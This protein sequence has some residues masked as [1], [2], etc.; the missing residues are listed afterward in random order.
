MPYLE[1]EELD[2]GG[3]EAAEALERLVEGTGP[4]AE[5][6]GWIRYA[7]SLSDAEIH[8]IETLA[9]EVRTEADAFVVIGIGGSYLGARAVIESLG[10]SHP[11]LSPPDERG[12]PLIFYAGNH[13]SGEALEALLEVLADRSVYLNVISKSGT[14][15]EPGL[16]FRALRNH[17]LQ[18]YG[19]E[20]TA[21]RI[22]TTTDATRGVLR[23]VTEEEGYRS[24]TIPGDVGGRYSVLTPVG[25]FPI[26]V[27]GI[28][29]DALLEGAASMSGPCEARDP[30][31][32]PALVYAAARN[33][34]WRKGFRQEMLVAYDPKFQY[35][36]EWWKQLFGESEGKEGKGLFPASALFTTDLHSLGQWIQEGP[37]TLFETM[38]HV[39]R[40]KAALRVPPD[41]SGMEDGLGYLEGRSWPEIQQK[42][43][44]GTRLA[45]HRGGV[46]VM[47][48][49]VPC[50]D[51]FHLGQMIYFFEMACGISG[52]MLG[53]NPFDQPGVEAYKRNMFALLGKPGF[54][55]EA[56]AL[57]EAGG[58]LEGRRV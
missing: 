53:V 30:S 39:A 14:T 55:Q 31:G 20:K 32:N 45:H 51:A 22:I 56:I 23:K 5:F 54:E 21:R 28:G 40:E 3:R 27:A 29:L 48:L 35:F 10:P 19:K 49:E 37:R 24:F 16:A 42:A 26:A 12:G 25:L 43:F 13:L 1:E 34:L 47:V 50:R 2:A 38:I 17:L 46:P 57:A 6:R 41:P 36:A 7:E 9:E 58:A 52:Y 4:G 18:R 33:L 11:A 44:E 15:T 8:G